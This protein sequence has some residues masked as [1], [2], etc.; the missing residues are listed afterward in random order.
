[1]STARSTSGASRCAQK[2][3]HGDHSP[4]RTRGKPVAASRPTL[5]RE[6]LTRAN[7]KD[8]RK[9]R[10]WSASRRGGRNEPPAVLGEDR[11]RWS[12]RRVNLHDPIG[13]GSQ[14]QPPVASLAGMLPPA[15]R[16]NYTT[17]RASTSRSPH[18]RVMCR[19]VD[20]HWKRRPRSRTATQAHHRI[21]KC[22]W[23]LWSA[24]PEAS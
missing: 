6:S 12:A 4:L 5:K 23:V 18:C 20:T 16:R 21:S 22:C 7:R 3:S 17:T 15:C 10:S 9:L 14:R 11:S 2:E 24:A 8:I 13:P 1:M 19:L